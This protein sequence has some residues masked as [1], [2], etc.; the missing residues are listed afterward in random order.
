MSTERFIQIIVGTSLLYETREILVQLAFLGLVLAFSEFGFRLG[1]RRQTN[2]SGETRSQVSTI[3]AA[4]LGILG[5]LLGFT[6]AMSVSRFERRQQDVLEEANAIG[7]AYLRTQLLP[8]DPGNSIRHALHDYLTVRVQFGAVG[9]DAKRIEGL[10]S[11][12]ARLQKQF[13]DEAAAYAQK[14]PLRANLLMQSLNQVIDLEAAR[15]KGFNDHV[16][17]SVIYADAIVGLLAAMLVGYSYSLSGRRNLVSM[18]ALALAITIVLSVI[19]DLDRSRSG[20][21]HVSQQPM[22]DLQQSF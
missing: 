11:E 4:L 12:G 3:E 16:P 19:I 15:W 20:F 7:T 18:C 21:I 13:W 10:R 9:T 1:R 2:I 14:E 8:T 17:A 6:V 5:L 22:I